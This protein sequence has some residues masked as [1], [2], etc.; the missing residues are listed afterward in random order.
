METEKIINTNID[1][2]LRH[3]IG[4]AMNR[5]PRNADPLAPRN[6][7]EGN[8]MSDAEIDENN[9]SFEYQV[10]EILTELEEL[11]IDKNKKYGNS[12]LNP[13]RIFSKADPVEQ[14]KVRLDDKLSRVANQQGNEDEDVLT[15]IM[16]YIILMKIALRKI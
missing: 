7:E 3:N 6:K 13:K 2:P 15:D 14:L 12:A 9:H 16:G 4:G 11:L 1:D 10:R 8:V 5:P